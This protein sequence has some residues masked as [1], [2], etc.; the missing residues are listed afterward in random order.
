MDQYL[1]KDAKQEMQT[2][3]KYMLFIAKLCPA[4]IGNGHLAENCERRIGNI[5]S[6]T[7]NEKYISA[8]DPKNIICT[9]G[10]SDTQRSCLRRLFINIKE[11]KLQ[12]EHCIIFKTFFLV[13]YFRKVLKFA[14]QEL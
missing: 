10:G 7:C 13:E 9:T 5:C 11:N 2:V 3:K 8:I 12:S 4:T 6:F 14:I 1:L